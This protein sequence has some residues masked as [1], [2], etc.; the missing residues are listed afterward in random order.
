MAVLAPMAKASTA[1]APSAKPQLLVRL[2][3]RIAH[4]AHERIEPSPDPR[5]PHGFLDLRHAAELDARLSP[6]FGLA[7]AVL[8]QVV[9]AAVHVIPQLA[10]EIPFQ[11]VAS[12]AEEIEEP[13]HGLCPLVE[14][15][16][17]RAAVSR[18][19]LAFSTASCL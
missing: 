10:I 3:Y 11:P 2:A 7:Q 16:P 14:D 4:V 9:D 8:D 17:D 15:Q 6:G 19:Q 12:P 5:V 1:P 18:S 13:R